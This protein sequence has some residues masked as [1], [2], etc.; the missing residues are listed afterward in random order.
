[1]TDSLFSGN[2]ATDTG[3][4]LY[5]SNSDSVIGGTTLRRNVAQEAGG[6]IE[7]NTDARTSTDHT[8]GGS[9]FRD[10]M[11]PSNEGIDIIEDT[12]FFNFATITCGAGSSNCFCDADSDAGGDIS[13]NSPDDT[14]SGAGIDADD[15]CCPM[16]TNYMCTPPIF[17]AFT[18]SIIDPLDDDD[19]D[20]MKEM[21][22]EDKME[23]LEAI[24]EEG[25][26]QP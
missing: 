24:E 10:N 21:S 20:T 3:G 22:T 26:D 11:A 17:P 2:A 25:K 8:I 1:V 18:G 5:I 19:D 23:M 9:I 13:T 12:T 6:A 4:A 7:Y 15:G 14:C 16:D